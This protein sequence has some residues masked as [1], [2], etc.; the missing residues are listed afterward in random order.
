MIEGEVNA[1]YEPV[2]SLPVQGPAG[3]TLE[4]DAVV[5]TGFNGFLTL[6]TVLVAELS[7]PFA[8]IG[9]A[10]LANGSEV[11]FDVHDVTVL[12]DGMPR[13]IE[14]AAADGTP[15]VG[16][17]LLDRHNLKIEVAEGGRVVIQSM[18]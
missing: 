13:N 15:L 10:V 2:I 5:D 7:L 9:R 4:I 6:P 8:S 11:A 14:A 3:Q 17:L 16:M 1:N 18:E 12:W